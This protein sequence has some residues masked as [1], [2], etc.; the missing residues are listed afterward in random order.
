MLTL[1][2]IRAAF[3]SGLVASAALVPGSAFADTA[4]QRLA[5]EPG[6]SSTQ[7]DAAGR[8]LVR[9]STQVDCAGETHCLVDLLWLKHKRLE[10]FRVACLMTVPTGG[11]VQQAVLHAVDKTDVATAT[12]RFDRIDDMMTVPLPIDIKTA[13]LDTLF[14]AGPREYIKINLFSDLGINTVNCTFTGYEYRL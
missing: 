4:M 10:I 6:T 5:S 12:E 7:L 3:Y 11:T 9:T 2:K 14:V 13:S 8:A 1:P